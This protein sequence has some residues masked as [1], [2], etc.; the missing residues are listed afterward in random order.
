MKRCP[1]VDSRLLTAILSV[2][3]QFSQADAVLDFFEP[4]A[5]DQ[6]SKQA[7][8]PI[9]EPME[10]QTLRLEAE[11]RTLTQDQDGTVREE[12]LGVSQS[13]VGLSGQFYLTR[14]IN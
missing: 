3:H 13:L 10:D 7:A 2:C 9:L 1:I 12:D 14:L 6:V 5:W 4:S 8:D 11:N